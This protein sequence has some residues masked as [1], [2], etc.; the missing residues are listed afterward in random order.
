MSERTY[1]H[2]LSKLEE[3]TKRDENRVVKDRAQRAFLSWTLPSLIIISLLFLGWL[4][5]R[6]ENRA[7]KKERE[8]E[9]G[10]RTYVG[11]NSSLA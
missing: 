3:V 5:T 4:D 11:T 8:K 6:R 9:G 10:G 2:L 1:S 7:K